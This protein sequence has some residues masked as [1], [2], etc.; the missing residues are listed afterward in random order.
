MQVDAG[1]ENV[2]NSTGPPRYPLR[3]HTVLG[4]LAEHAK[5][6]QSYAAVCL[7]LHSGRADDSILTLIEERSVLRVGGEFLLLPV[8]LAHIAQAPLFN[9]RNC[10]TTAIYLLLWISFILKLIPDE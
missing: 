3:G 2:T 8:P 5:G 1:L 9:D 7:A 10:K 4:M 6:N